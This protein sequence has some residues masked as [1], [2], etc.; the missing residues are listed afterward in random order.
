MNFIVIM[1]DTL[2]PDFLSAYG[3]DWVHTPASAAFAQR[4]AVFDNCYVGSFPTIPNRTDLFT[5]RF[6]EPFHPWLPLSYDETTLVDRMRENGYVTQLICDTP[7]MIQGGHNFDYPFHAWEMIRGNEVDRYGMDHDPVAFPFKDFSKVNAWKQNIHTS[8]YIRSARGRRVEEDWT[9]YKTYQT[10][11]NWLQRNWRHEKFFL[12]IDGFDPHEPQLP[13]QQYM[14]LYQPGYQGDMFLAGVPDP[15]RLTEA[16]MRNIKARYAGM[17]T[18]VDRLVGRLLQTLED[19]RIA[20]KT[21]VVWISDHGTQLGENGAVLEKNCAFNPTAR[22]VMMVRAPAASAGGRQAAGKHFSDLVQHADLAPTL[23]DLAG[24]PVPDRMQGWSFLPL[25]RGKPYNGRQTALSAGG[26]VIAP[27]AKG[28]NLR[29][30]A[31]DQRWV[32]R[33]APNPADRILNDIAND[34]AQTRN[35][36]VEHP[37]EVQRLHEAVLDFLRAHEAQPPLIRLFETGNPGDLTGY[38]ARRPG[39]ENFRAYFSNCYYSP[40]LPDP[41]GPGAH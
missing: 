41:T 17:V 31:R 37:E 25:L 6:G 4:A 14:D 10:A 19:L 12:W 23:L 15:S 26:L 3:N 1:N 5:G 7:H 40:I 9:P 13:P 22:Q 29:I 24:L 16:E 2:R 35:V 21:C 28:R 8:Q 38:V 27:A 11:I 20:D 36:A 18:F 39:C 32:L 33:D 30:V 34:P